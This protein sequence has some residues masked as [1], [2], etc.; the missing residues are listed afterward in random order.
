MIDMIRKQSRRAKRDLHQNLYA[1]SKI[2]RTLNFELSLRLT[3]I[4]VKATLVLN[5]HHFPSC[6][7]F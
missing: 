2:Y 3:L 4:P 7:F 1:N 5:K 6:L